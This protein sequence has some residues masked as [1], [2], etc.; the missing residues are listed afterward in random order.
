M[1]KNNTFEIEGGGTDAHTHT[2][3]T[4]LY[5]FEMYLQSKL[6]VKEDECS[7]R[8][9]KQYEEDDNEATEHA[10]RLES[11]TTTSETSE[12]SEEGGDDEADEDEEEVGGVG[13]VRPV[14]A[15]R[16][17]LTNE[18]VLSIQQNIDRSSKQCT[19]T[20]LK[21]IHLILASIC[22]LYSGVNTYM[23]IIFRV[24]FSTI[25]GQIK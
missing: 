18:G 6:S 3:T 23:Y 13:G 12:E 4:S 20:K 16:D 21:H 22:F 1:S 19:E 10:A 17:V 24:I 8:T 25:V 14:Q 9:T 5:I 11:S 7:N 15:G 2:R